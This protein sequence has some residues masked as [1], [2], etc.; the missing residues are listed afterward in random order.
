MN[1]YFLIPATTAKI[2]NPYAKLAIS[3]GILSKEATSEIEKDPVIVEA[4]IKK[5]K[6]HI[7]KVIK[8]IIFN[9]LINSSSLNIFW[10]SFPKL[11]QILETSNVLSQIY[12]IFCYL[13]S[14]YFSHLVQ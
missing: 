7:F 8:P 1:L 3:V 11:L 10:S 4:K 14:L 2:F 9:T 5:Q 6:F 13:K 12:D